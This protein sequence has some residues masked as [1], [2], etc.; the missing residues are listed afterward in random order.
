MRTDCTDRTF[1]HVTTLAR[2]ILASTSYQNIR[3]KQEGNVVVVIFVILNE[4]R[5]SSA[6]LYVIVLRT[7]T[8]LLPKDGA[9]EINCCMAV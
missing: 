8:Q 2:R 1:V 9:M 7:C 5:K 3:D 6:T 4:I